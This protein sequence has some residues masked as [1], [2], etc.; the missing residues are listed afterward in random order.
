MKKE[1][2]YKSVEGFTATAVQSIKFTPVLVNAVNPSPGPLKLVAGFTSQGGLLYIQV[3]GSAWSL[4]PEHV[5]GI[6]IS[7]NGNQVGVCQ[8]YTNEK[9]IHRTLVPVTFIVRNVGA[10][11]N[12]IQLEGFDGTVADQFDYFNVT[13]T[14]Y[15]GLT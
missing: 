3:S 14:E 2:N 15:I 5:I 1:K 10:G 4:I 7:V 8:R 6:K 9:I 12:F 11:N 13:V